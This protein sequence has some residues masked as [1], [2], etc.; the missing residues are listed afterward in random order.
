[1]LASSHVTLQPACDPLEATPLTL[2][3]A[4][5]ACIPRAFVAISEKAYSSPRNIVLRI[6]IE[7][8]GAMTEILLEGV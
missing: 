6:E 2:L 3:L 1:M 7:N 5:T 8:V 4:S